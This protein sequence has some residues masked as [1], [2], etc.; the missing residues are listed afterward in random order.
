[1]NTIQKIGII[2]VAF[3]TLSLF[4]CKNNKTTTQSTM[5]TTEQGS[6]TMNDAIDEE[7]ILITVLE[8]MPLF[9]GKPPEKEF[10]NYV[11]ENIKCPYEYYAHGSFYGRV[12]VEFFIDTDGSVTDTK[13]LR[14]I[15][16]VLDA[17]AL[18]V[19][20]SSPKWTPDK[21]HGKP[22]KVRYVF[23]VEFKH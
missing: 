8:D 17:E 7:Q 18:R 10:R 23:P 9:N 21:Q 4:S 20:N 15:D 14:G 6:R 12:F 1:M 11:N 19:I 5:E 22:V 13:V 16:P 3:I 2:V